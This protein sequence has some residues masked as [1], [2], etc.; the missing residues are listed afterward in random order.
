MRERDIAKVSRDYHTAPTMLRCRRQ[1]VSTFAAWQLA[2]PICHLLTGQ[3]LKF[4]PC[5][6]SEPHTNQ[7]GGRR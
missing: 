1:F 2:T 6:A 4:K 3:Y 5:R 7:A